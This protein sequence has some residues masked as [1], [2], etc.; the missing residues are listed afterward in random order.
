MKHNQ[1]VCCRRTWKKAMPNEMP[2]MMP[3]LASITVVTRVKQP[4]AAAAWEKRMIYEV[5]MGKLQPGGP[6]TDHS[7]FCSGPPDLKKYR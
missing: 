4:C 6:D 2:A 1:V 5:G 7:T 3:R